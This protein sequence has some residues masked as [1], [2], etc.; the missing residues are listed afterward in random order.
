MV[1]GLT[2]TN[3][4][5][6]R[7]ELPQAGPGFAGRR[8]VWRTLLAVEWGCVVKTTNLKDLRFCAPFATYASIHLVR[9][10]VP[11]RS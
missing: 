10:F 9:F 2:P 1:R 4:Q 5:R 6:F 7:I 11:A 8:V 3:G